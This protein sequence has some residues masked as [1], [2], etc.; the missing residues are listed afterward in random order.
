MGAFGITNKCMAIPVSDTL[1]VFALENEAQGLFDKF[2]AIFCGVGKVNA[3]YRLTQ[4]LMKWQR[5]HGRMPGRVLNLGSAGSPSF[6]AG[7]LVNCTKFIQRDMDT[8]PLGTPAFA[9][10]F[11][12]TPA[13]LAYGLRFEEYE[14]GICGSGDN[15]VTD[16]KI[17]PWNVMDM[18]GYALAKICMLEKVPFGCL[19]FITDGAD[20]HAA[21]TWEEALKDAARDLRTALDAINTRLAA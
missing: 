13:A 4:A 17:S 3:A 2:S 12:D 16:G 19:K 18:E 9:T 15:F 10:P 21:N 14:E 1:I 20:G 6:K 8:T 7:T 5:E 11:D